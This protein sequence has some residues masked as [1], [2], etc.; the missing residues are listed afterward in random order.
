[1]IYVAQITLYVEWLF[2]SKLKLRVKTEHKEI[3]YINV[4]PLFTNTS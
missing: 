1:M 2:K 4:L 3:S